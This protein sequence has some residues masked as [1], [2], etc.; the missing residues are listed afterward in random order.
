[1][2]HDVLT[3]E[4]MLK[5]RKYTHANYIAGLFVNYHLFIGCAVIS[6]M[7]MIYVKINGSV[8]VG[9]LLYFPVKNCE[10]SG[11]CCTTNGFSLPMANILP[12]C[13]HLL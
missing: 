13:C 4:R 10:C 11:S 5:M 1:M 7:R 12:S 6:L 2:F 8:A 9:I 3:V